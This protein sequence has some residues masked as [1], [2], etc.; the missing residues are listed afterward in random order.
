MSPSNGKSHLAYQ[1]LELDM[2]LCLL[3]KVCSTPSV[4]LSLHPAAKTLSRNHSRCAYRLLAAP[5]ACLAPNTMT[6]LLLPD[7]SAN[8]SVPTAT[9]LMLCPKGSRA[10]GNQI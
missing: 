9:Q 6:A 1:L 4:L 10:L 5:F 3:Q 8:T 7:F 2:Q